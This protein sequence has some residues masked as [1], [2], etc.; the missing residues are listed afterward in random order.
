MESTKVVTGIVR[1]S[2]AHVFEPQSIEEGGDKKYS[3]SLIIPKSDKKT[4]AEIEKAINALKEEYKTK[5]GKLPA[6][7]KIP[8][9]DGDEEKEDDET[10]ANSVF[11]SASSKSK[12][13]V[14]DR[15]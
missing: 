14:V 10:Y 2:Y 12:P 4:I 8:L 9:R 15:M 7:F 1:F 11:L 13:G 6:K 5:N 3:V